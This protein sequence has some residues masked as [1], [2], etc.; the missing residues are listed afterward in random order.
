MFPPRAC[1]FLSRTRSMTDD[2]PRFGSTAGGLPQYY[3]V[4]WYVE[5]FFAI[6]NKKRINSDKSPRSTSWLT[7]L[8]WKVDSPERHG[9]ARPIYQRRPR[10]IPGRAGCVQAPP[11]PRV[12]LKTHS[13]DESAVTTPPGP[14]SRDATAPHKTPAPRQARFPPLPRTSP[15]WARPRSSSSAPSCAASPWS[16]PIPKVRAA[17]SLGSWPN[18][19]C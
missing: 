10:K 13:S 12:R 2:L 3:F 5:G 16:S 8:G 7:S 14:G 6:G 11:H 18:L 9:T 15:R 17:P 1:V 19:F 4:I